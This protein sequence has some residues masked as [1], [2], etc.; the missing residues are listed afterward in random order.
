[1]SVFPTASNSV[2][3]GST[4]NYLYFGTIGT[5]TAPYN[6][7]GTLSHEAGHCLN[8]YHTWGDDS[9]VCTGTDNCNDT[10]NSGNMNYGNIEDGS[11]AEQPSATS[12]INTS[13]GLETDN[14]TT[15]SPGVLYEDFMD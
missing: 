4:I 15:T 13:T 8:L 2:Y 10:P 6:L 7:G 3:Y 1:M 12:T 9:G 14:C 5:A 11:L